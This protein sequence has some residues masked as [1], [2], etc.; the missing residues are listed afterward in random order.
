VG[1]VMYSIHYWFCPD[2][3]TRQQTLDGWPPMCVACKAG[4]KKAE[5]YLG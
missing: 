1:Q 3:G 2:C 4:M 5:R